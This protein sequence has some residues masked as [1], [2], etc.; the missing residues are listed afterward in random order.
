MTEN[1]YIFCYVYV[2]FAILLDKSFKKIEENCALRSSFT[3]GVYH[4]ILVYV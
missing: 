3:N 4:T 1:S 2:L